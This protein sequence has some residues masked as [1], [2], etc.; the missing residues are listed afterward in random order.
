MVMVSVKCPKCG[1]DIES[2]LPKNKSMIIRE[3]PACREEIC[4]EDG[5]C[6]TICS[7]PKEE[8]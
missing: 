5:G 4:R 2:E 6:I 1:Y 3:C 8:C 7:C